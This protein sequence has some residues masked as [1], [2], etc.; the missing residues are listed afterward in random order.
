M[1]NNKGFTLI[2]VLTTI[3]IILICIMVIYANLALSNKAIKHSA[4]MQSE[5]QNISSTIAEMRTMDISEIKDKVIDIGDGNV[6]YI[7]KTTL[8]EFSI[9]LNI[10]IRNKYT[11][12]IKTN[13]VTMLSTK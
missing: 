11:S 3:A 4:E 2:E 10:I 1:K 9:K 6:I 7:S 5:N 12:E 13:F 8:N